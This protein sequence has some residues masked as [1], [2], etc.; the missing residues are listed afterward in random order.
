MS[1]RQRI[2]P[3]RGMLARVTKMK[4]PN[5]TINASIPNNLDSWIIHPTPECSTTDA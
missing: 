3:P 1:H 5:A 2:R 4:K